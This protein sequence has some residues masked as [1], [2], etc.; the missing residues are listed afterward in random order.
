M[1]KSPAISPGFAFSGAIC[2]LMP[3]EQN[4][5]VTLFIPES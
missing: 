1:I 3:K 4:R 2:Y 5:G